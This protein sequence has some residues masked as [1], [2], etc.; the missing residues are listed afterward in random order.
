MKFLAF[1]SVVAFINLSACSTVDL[2]QAALENKNATP[3]AMQ[4]KN[5]VQRAC[6]SMTLA[7]Q[8]KGWNKK[9]HAQRTQIA[10][11][12]LLNGIKKDETKQ[13]SNS[14]V[15]VN[16][17]QFVKD[18]E[19]A[20]KHIEQTTKA[21]EIFLTMADNTVQIDSE[22]SL[23]ETALLSAREAQNEL[24][25]TL[26]RANTSEARSQLVLLR[27]EIHKLK[28]I[29]NAYG[30]RMRRHIVNQAMNGGPTT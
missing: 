6:H 27:A 29:T 3:F 22:L 5:V 24:R 26:G 11:S 1:C 21:A 13:S 14:E 10:A 12:V 17:R 25:E 20:K 30:E 4:K 28:T 2:S 16:I 7:F 15:Y 23:L 9:E 18:I 8:A 19:L